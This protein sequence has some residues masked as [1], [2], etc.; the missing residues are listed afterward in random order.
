MANKKEDTKEIK[1]KKEIRRLKSI[2]KDVEEKRKKTCEGLINEAAFMRATLE[3]LKV[4]IDNDGPI[5]EM[6]QGEYTILREHPAVKTYN[7]M[8]QRYTNIIS[9]LASLLPKEVVKE[10]DD[11]FDDFTNDR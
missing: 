9:K 11:G 3:E 4:I 6:E 7:T 1:I 2:Y 5:D 8:I 10:S